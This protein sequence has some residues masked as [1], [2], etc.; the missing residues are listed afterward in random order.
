[1]LARKVIDDLQE[2]LADRTRWALRL[3]SDVQQGA[4]LVAELQ[5]E[6]TASNRWAKQLDSHIQVMESEVTRLSAEQQEQAA[7]IRELDAELAGV[8]GRALRR[9]GAI[10][11]KKKRF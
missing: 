11:R 3:E 6:L 2:E 8:L 5:S 7:R 9:V 10:F 1:M 4:V